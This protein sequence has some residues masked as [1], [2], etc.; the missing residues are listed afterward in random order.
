MYT[1]FRNIT[2]EGQVDY[3]PID[4]CR[5]ET[6]GIHDVYLTDMDGSLRSQ[7]LTLSTNHNKSGVIISASSP[8]LSFL[9]PENCVSNE[10]MCNKYCV[11]TCV[12]SIRYEIDPAGSEDYK[13]R[14]CKLDDNM[15]CVE[16]PGYLRSEWDGWSTRLRMFVAHLPDGAYEAAFINSE[17][18]EVWP[19]FANEIVADNMCFT[20]AENENSFSIS[21]RKP[22]TRPS[23]C[24]ELVDNGDIEESNSIPLHWL[25]RFGELELVPGAGIGNSNAL[26]S[27]NSVDRKMFVQYLDERCLQLLVGRKYKLSAAVKLTSEADN[28]PKGCS[29]S[30]D[31][32]SI[33]VRSETGL[34]QRVASLSSAT[35]DQESTLLP[36][37]YYLLEG[38][39]EID[40]I[41]ANTSQIH[42]YIESYGRSTR[43]YIDNVSM[44]LL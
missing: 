35:F 10:G 1:S 27:A 32:P 18:K 8:M 24:N 23:W 19:T 38:V 33:G 7:Q 41:L 6:S 30:D 44:Y 20:A 31:C 25:Y 4:F 17:G 21:L 16:L 15:T 37:G 29:N 42:L 12:R 2:L 26:S 11:A 22:S 14:V 28:E 40:E 3:T 13:L 34:L 5:T 9:D 43:M 39:I 36:D